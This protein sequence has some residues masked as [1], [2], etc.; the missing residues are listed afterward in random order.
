MAYNTS[1]KDI[2]SLSSPLKSLFIKELQKI[3]VF[4]DE[5]Q[6]G[7]AVASDFDRSVQILGLC[8]CHLCPIFTVS[9]IMGLGFEER[10]ES[11]VFKLWLV[12]C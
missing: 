11:Q 8:L 3:K 1:K 2:T 4:C 7:T 9:G 6:K 5:K 12:P 10:K